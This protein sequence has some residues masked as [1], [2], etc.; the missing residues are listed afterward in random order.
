MYISRDGSVSKWLLEAGNRGLM[1]ASLLPHPEVPCGD[2][3]AASVRGGTNRV[4][5][6]ETT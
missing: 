1:P 4:S 6:S 5:D 2:P 3:P